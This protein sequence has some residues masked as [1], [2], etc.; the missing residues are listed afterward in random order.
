M[1]DYDQLTDDEFDPDMEGDDSNFRIRDP[2]QPPRAHPFSTA[3]LHGEFLTA[4]RLFHLIH[5][6]VGLIHQGLIDLNPPYQRGQRDYRL[7]Y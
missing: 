1:S 3:D 6:L 5:L 2:L 7:T 4:Q